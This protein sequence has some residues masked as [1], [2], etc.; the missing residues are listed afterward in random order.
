[1]GEQVEDAE[2]TGW[3]DGNKQL[4]DDEPPEGMAPSCWQFRA[5]DELGDQDQDDEDRGL[6]RAAQQ[7]VQGNLGLVGDHLPSFSRMRRSSLTSAGEMRFRVTK[8]ASMGLREPPKTRS[9]K[10]SLTAEMQSASENWG[11]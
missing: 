10:E 7:P 2:R 11:L 5:E 1:V 6:E 8:W 3:E 4:E 9:R